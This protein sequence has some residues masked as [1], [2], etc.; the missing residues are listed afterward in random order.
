MRTF[1]DVEFGPGPTDAKPLG[2]I[3]TS[4]VSIDELLR[5]LGTLAAYPSSPEFRN[6]EIV[7][8]QMRSPLTIKLAL[9]AIPAD[10]V[11]AFLEIC[12]EIILSRDRGGRHDAHHL[13]RITTALD[14]CGPE[15]HARMTAIETQRLYA[16]VARLQDAEVPLQRVEVRNA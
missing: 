14:L 16:H 13:A 9:L 1:I 15:A 5:D 12:R 2:D 4:L 11:K 8:I 7:A 3:A 10:A 6:I